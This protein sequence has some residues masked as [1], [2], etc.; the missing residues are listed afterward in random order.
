MVN[1]GWLVGF[2][3]FWLVFCICII[4]T[5]IQGIILKWFTPKN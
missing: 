3:V 5:I 2:S 1:F 4:S